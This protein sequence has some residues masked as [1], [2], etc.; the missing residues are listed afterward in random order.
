[1]ALASPRIYL[2][3]SVPEQLRSTVVAPL[4]VVFERMQ[5]GTFLDILLGRLRQCARAEHEEGAFF[6]L[7]W[8]LR[9]GEIEIHL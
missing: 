7:F 8:T 5:V 9:S 3:S 6:R 1:M 4:I 2:K